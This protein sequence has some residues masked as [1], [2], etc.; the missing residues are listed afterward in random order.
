MTP[1]PETSP[2]GQ[3]SPAARRFAARAALVL[4]GAALALLLLEVLLQAAAYA[5]WRSHRPAEWI[6]G[7]RRRAILCAGDSFTF[8]LGS[9]VPSASYPAQLERLLEQ[10]RPGCFAVANRGWPGR[11]SR[12]VLG[13]LSTDLDAIKPELVYVLVGINDFWSLPEPLAE[14]EEEAG[15]P[16]GSFPLLWRTRRLTLW[17]AAKLRGS[18]PARDGESALP[19]VPSLA[20]TWHVGPI[21]ATFSPGG[22]LLLNGAEFLWT[23]EGDELLIRQHGQKEAWRARLRSQ[24]DAILLEEA[25]S[26]LLRLLEPGPVP[27]G[28]DDPARARLEAIQSLCAA[29]RQDEACAELEKLESELAAATDQRSAELLMRARECCGGNALALAC[30]LLARQPRSLY[31]LEVVFRQA[32]RAEDRA[33]GAATLERAAGLLPSTDSQRA[34]LLRVAARLLAPERLAEALRLIVEAYAVDGD[35]RSTVQQLSTAAL[36]RDRAALRAA[37]Q[38]L[39]AAGVAGGEAAR[40]FERALAPEDRVR[41]TLALHL[42]R[43]AAKCRAEGA[44]LALLVYPEQQDTV[45]SAARAVASEQDV[46]L[47]DVRAAFAE[48]LRARP[49]AELFIADGHCTDAGYAVIADLVAAHVL[50]HAR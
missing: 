23:C 40:L 6:T 46:D 34:V 9:S 16:S 27:Q 50:E 1:V 31:A 33:R 32:E 20:G 17:L 21:E 48:L 15:A 37:F 13:A 35:A 28:T 5:V 29:G 42:G 12:D 3:A 49:R 45:E 36:G 11:D 24:G 22:R 4:G 2:A 19:L 30:D 47:I 8:G 44:V 10:R 43:I 18:E 39:V 41:E 7:P 26:G 14:G 38:P 25:C